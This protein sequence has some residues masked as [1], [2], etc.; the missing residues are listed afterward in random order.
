MRQ[1]RAVRYPAAVHGLLYLAVG[2]PAGCLAI[3]VACAAA[4]RRQ[5]GLRQ[6]DIHQRRVGCG[7][8]RAG[9]ALR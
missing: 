5:Q 4:R 3:V 9:L 8:R 2:R 6:G 1:A 7:R